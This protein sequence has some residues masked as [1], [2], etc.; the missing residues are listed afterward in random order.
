MPKIALEGMRFYGYH[1]FY[2]EEQVVGTEFMVDVY[3]DTILVL[4][5]P[6]VKIPEDDI[7]ATLS[8]ET[9]YQVCKIEMK[10]PVKLI[11]TLATRIL[12]RLKSQF[13]NAG[14]DDEALFRLEVKSI[15]VRVSKFHPPLGG[16]VER[17]YV[18]VSG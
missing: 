14:D 13:R 17:A 18:E 1:G 9:V 11:E 2:P 15:L 6:G 8:Y 10:K 12:S 5:A 4:L 3:I 7:Q 16:R